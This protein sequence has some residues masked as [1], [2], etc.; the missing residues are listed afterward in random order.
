MA[1]SRQSSTD[2]SETVAMALP[3]QSCADGRDGSYDC[4]APKLRGRFGDGSYG[5]VVPKLCGRLGDSNRCGALRL[6][7]RIGTVAKALRRQS[8]AIVERTGQEAAAKI[9]IILALRR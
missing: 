9:C 6:C 1:V 3:R 7:G 5:F 8:S 2:D 4:A